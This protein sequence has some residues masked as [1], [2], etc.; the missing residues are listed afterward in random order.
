MTVPYEFMM[1]VHLFMHGDNYDL[2]ELKDAVL[3]RSQ[4][5]ERV[6]RQ[7]DEV[8]QTRPVTV[9]W[10]IEHANADL[11]DEETLYRYLKEVY[12]YVFSDGP[13]PVTEG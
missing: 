2:D 11:G 3:E 9:D 4:W 10:Y 13:W 1:T 8:L 5:I 6:R 7:F 12:D